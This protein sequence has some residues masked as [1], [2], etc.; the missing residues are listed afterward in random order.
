MKS[1]NVKIEKVIPN[2]VNPRYINEDK[3]LKL[4]KSLQDFPEMSQA[5]PLIVNK[6]Y[7]VLGGN[8]RLKAMEKAGWVT[9]PV[10]VVDWSE[11]K[12][13]EFIIKDNANFGDWDWE[14]LKSEFGSVPLSDFGLDIPSTEF[15]PNLTPSF[16]TEEVTAED[17]SKASDEMGVGDAIAKTIEVICPNCAHEFHIKN[18]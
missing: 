16:N 7:K 6:D 5:R 1:Q 10:V 18:S 2:D 17:I 15:N 11:E 3:F 13:K 4:V 9:V 8:M 12:Q 14:I